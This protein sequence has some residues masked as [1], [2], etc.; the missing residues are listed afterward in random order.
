M[1]GHLSPSDVTHAYAKAARIQGAEIYLR[2]RVTDLRATTEG[3][4]EVITEEGVI[5]AEHVVNAGG[6]WRAKSVGW[7]ALSY[8]CCHGA[9]VHH[10]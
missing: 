9:H 3:G 8:P 2:N 7:L 5:H 6:L 4:W 1:H 10:Y